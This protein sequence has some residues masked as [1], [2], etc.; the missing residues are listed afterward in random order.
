VAKNVADVWEVGGAYDAFMGRWSRIVAREF[1]RWLGVHAHGKWL[2][3]GCGTGV[4]AQ[5]ILD[6]AAPV[7]VTGLDQAPGFISFAR[8]KINDPRAGFIVGAA[9]ALN[10]EPNMYDA[11]V[12]GLV[13][14]FVPDPDEAI[15]GLKQV[16]RP[17]GVLAAYVWDYAGTMQILRHFWDAAVQLDA[18]AVPLDEGARF[19]ICSPENLNALFEK[20][21]LAN[22]GVRT[23]DV[24]AHFA[25]FQ[26][27]WSPFLMGQGPAPGYVASL[28]IER[29]ARLRDM[30][31]SHLPVAPD[32]SIDLVARA[33]AVKGEKT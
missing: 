2:D 15:A 28:T 8:T 14:N 13:L 31:R 32:G 6:E 20:Q 12:M 18:D 4:L 29:Q 16:I 26:D 9:T 30:V 3:V 7:S 23:I 21:G 27:Y 25:D 17:G 22:V 11:A 1:L 24:G 5:T 33:F 19:P 10:L